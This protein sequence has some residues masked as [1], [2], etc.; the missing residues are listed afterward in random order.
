MSEKY[1][2][3]EA[4]GKGDLAK[5]ALMLKSNPSLAS[6]TPALHW[7][8]SRGQTAMVEF[9]L[10][11]NADVNAIDDYEGDTPLH[12]AA[13]GGHTGVAKLLI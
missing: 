2:F 1:E 3:R 13:Q 12:L 8:A 4:A 9:L 10:T 7:A 11:N 6:S 5:V